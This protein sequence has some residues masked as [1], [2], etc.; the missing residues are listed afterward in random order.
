MCTNPGVNLSKFSR[1]GE[2]AQ[3]GGDLLVT[4]PLPSIGPHLIPH[5]PQ[6]LTLLVYHVEEDHISFVLALHPWG[7]S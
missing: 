5:V 2:Y 4:R 3:R 7:C 6:L 1:T